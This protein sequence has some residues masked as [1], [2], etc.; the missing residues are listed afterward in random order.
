MIAG[1]C[2]P[3]LLQGPFRA[4]MIGDIAVQ[5]SASA[6]FHENEHIQDTKS[7]CDHDEEV[8]GHHRLCVIASGWLLQ[9]NR[10]S[11]RCF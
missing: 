2:F 7:G 9:R 3:Q 1:E 10:R 8:A 11:F 6:Q 4:G 5:D